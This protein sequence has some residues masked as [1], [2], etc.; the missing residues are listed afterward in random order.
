MNVLLLFIKNPILGKVKTRLAATVG[1]DAAL[2]I[3][4]QL[5][6][7]TRCLAEQVEAVRFLFYSDFIAQ[8]DDWQTTHFVKKIQSGKHLGE[9]MYNAF[10]EALEKH[11]KAVIIGSD[12][13][14]LSLT[15]IERAYAALAHYD[16]VLGPAKDGGYYLLGLKKSN[17]ALFE[18]IDWSTD[19]VLKQSIERIETQQ[20]S[21][22]LLPLLSDVDTEEDWLEVKTFF[23]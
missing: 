14:T 22:F 13:A 9:R 8:K 5:L 3:Y 11:D 4:T 20:L 23:L 17:K 16:V 19:Q 21:Y 7:Y 6:Y 15:I 1:N 2:D 18:G 12:C 10:D